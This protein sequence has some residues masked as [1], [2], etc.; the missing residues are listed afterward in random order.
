[1][2]ICLSCTR[3]P[4]DDLFPTERVGLLAEYGASTMSLP[5]QLDLD[6]DFNARREAAMARIIAM[7]EE[8]LIDVFEVGAPDRRV[9]G[10]PAMDYKNLLAS[11][12]V[13]PSE[14]EIVKD[15]ITPAGGGITISEANLLSE[16]GSASREYVTKLYSV[17]PVGQLV[18]KLEE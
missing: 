18:V 10:L 11:I 8:N 17:K 14:L 13:S 5:G 2:G 4:D 15:E 3:A 1:M 7:T 16:L 12:E 9:N 6:Q